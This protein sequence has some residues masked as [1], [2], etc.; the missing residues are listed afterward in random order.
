MRKTKGKFEDDELKGFLM[1]FASDGAIPKYG[2]PDRIILA[3]NIPKTSV[4]KI[5]KK[6]LRKEYS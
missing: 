4:G 1:K 2:V 5:D 6:A 3:E